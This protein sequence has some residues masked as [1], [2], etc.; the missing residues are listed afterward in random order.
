MLTR[1]RVTGFKNLV[2]VDVHFGPFTCVA[3]ANGVG[4]SNL[5]DAIRFLSALASGTLADAA[6]AVRAHG[7]THGDARDLF[8]RVG[9]AA[10]D[11]M[12][13]VADMLIPRAGVGDYGEDMTA[14]NTLL[15]YTLELRSS[16]AKVGN[17]GLEL[18]TEELVPVP[19]DEVAAALA[20]PHSAAWR[21]SA[22]VLST[23]P[24]SGQYIRTSVGPDGR[25]VIRNE[26][27]IP[28]D[29]PDKTEMFIENMP[30]L[31]PRTMVSLTPTAFLARQEM[32][33]WQLLHLEPT[34]LREPDKFAA[35]PRLGPD[36]SHLPAT[37]DRLARTAPDG[38]ADRVYAEVADRLHA[39]I[40]DVRSI[41]VDRDEKGEY[42][43]VIAFD[44]LG[45]RLPARSLSDG[46]LRF[47]ALA[48]LEADPEAVGV[49]CFEEPENGIHPDRIP[50]ILSLL[51]A[52]AVDPNLP[53]EAGNPLRQV[54]V[55]THSPKVVTELRDDEILGALKRGLGRATQS[56][57]RVSFCAMP[58]TWRG[59][60]KPP[61][62]ELPLGELLAYLT[63]P[64]VR[65]T[66]SD[67]PHVGNGA[68]SRSPVSRRIIDRPDV[69][70][71]FDFGSDGI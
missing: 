63:G 32:Q 45:T 36:G 59:E 35:P 31:M 49:I 4:K 70:T 66:S 67:T 8:T 5:F 61:P 33:S 22:V 38:D 71:R 41:G 30:A 43:S 19:A 1:L 57:G 44:A 58:G 25:R 55:N 11:R 12:T 42:L 15:R 17:G 27:I 53:V 54:I 2:D 24:N 3:G 28:G 51:R 20:F 50:A 14:R 34:A 37:L 62:A 7:S 56:S 60:L 47:L 65:A 40:Q 39:L 46:T 6:R 64:V 13:F 21:D 9:D 48:T 10:V 69:Q 68:A 16:P 52:I 23:P 29:P 26:H 18:H